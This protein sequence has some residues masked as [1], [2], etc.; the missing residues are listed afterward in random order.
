MSSDVEPLREQTA[1]TLVSGI[2]GD[3]QHLVDQQLRLTRREI[4]EELRLRTVA[5]GILGLGV[6]TLFLSA[7]AD[8]MALS[9]LL[10]WLASPSGSDPAWLPLWGCHTV[11]ATILTIGG[12]IVT[13]VGLKRFRSIKPFPNPVTDILQEGDPWTTRQK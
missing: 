6:A 5:A 3:L 2:L 4:E 8:C 13:L 10:Y 11:L 9:H 7:F 1:A 12:V